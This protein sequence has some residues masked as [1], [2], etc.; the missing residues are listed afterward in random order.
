VGERLQSGEGRLA[1][2]SPCPSRRAG[3][4][5]GQEVKRLDFT[6]QTGQ[7]SRGGVAVGGQRDLL[8]CP[9]DQTLPFQSCQRPVPL[10][11]FGS[12]VAHRRDGQPPAAGIMRLLLPVGLEG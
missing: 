2:P 4:G 10:F 12:I 11:F 3:G 9:D 8:P 5:G 6:R 7:P 1:N